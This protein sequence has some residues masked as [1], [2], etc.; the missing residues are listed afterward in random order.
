MRTGNLN[1][2]VPEVPAVPEVLGGFLRVK[3][4]WDAEHTRIV[5]LL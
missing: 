2:Q 5:L 1:Y 3:R 4:S